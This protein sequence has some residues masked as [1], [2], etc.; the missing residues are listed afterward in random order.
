MRPA[1]A[2]SVGGIFDGLGVGW[3]RMSPPPD[4]GVR[5]VNDTLRNFCGGDRASAAE[6]ADLFMDR[7]RFRRLAAAAA[8]GREVRG[9]EM[10]LRTA[11]GR[12]RVCLL[13]LAPHRGPRGEVRWIDGALRDVTVERHTHRALGDSRGLFRAIFMHSPVGM[14]VL[15]PEGRLV[16]WNPAAREILGASER[17]LFNKPFRDLFRDREWQTVRRLIRRGR[18]SFVDVETQVVHAEG[19]VLDVSLSFARFQDAGGAD[20]GAI[21]ILHDIT[22][23]K[24][25]ER[26]IKESENKIRVILDN[27]AAAITLTDEKERIVSWNRYTEELL[28]R[29]REDLYLRPVSSLYPQEEWARIREANI[30]M[31]GSKHHFETRVIR[32]DGSCVDV[33]LS[34]NVLKDA[35][36]RIIGSVGIMQDITEQ[37]KFQQML[38]KAKTMAEEANS[39]KT[40]FLANM[41]HEVRTPMNTIIGMVDL[42]LDTNLTGEQRENLLAVKN[43]A[44]IL[45]NLINDIL[46]LSRVEAG[47]IQL[48]KIEMNVH[49]IVQSVC[50]GLI[51]LAR[52]KNLEL[53]W[54]VAPEV[55]ETVIGDPVRLRQVLVNLINNAVK[56]TFKGAITTRVEVEALDEQECT[57]RFSVIDEGVG[58][59]PEKLERIFD[60]FTQA[61]AST[62]RRF[63]GT[64]L[65]LAIS[66]RLVELMGGSIWVES[67]EF[68]GSTFSFTARFTRG[69]ETVSVP[70]EEEARGASSSDSTA[71]ER[72]L[73][74]LLAEDNIVNQKIAVRM[75]EKRGW[76]VT[77]V[78]NGR[79]VLEC[80]EHEDGFDLILMD[81]QMPVMD[82]LEA[83]RRIREAEKRSGGHIPIVALTAR[84][85][86]GDRRRCL[87]AGMD[88]YVSKPIDRQKLYEAVEALFR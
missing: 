3:F 48:E 19:R 57:L 18:R 60:A 77:A 1:H 26:R 55:P 43:A 13:S 34:V 68:R 85:M 17:E 6:A 31:L 46:D 40:L 15:D 63:G 72:P 59:P 61:D 47:K 16:A 42:T 5:A 32:G 87:D 38:M 35:D 10:E 83:T 14:I 51:V 8:S 9:E 41:S 80:L 4:G 66:R 62:T 30:R 76:R 23:Q 36:D 7:R 78:D 64:G 45:L 86:S 44:D 69:A 24:E 88:G 65:G 82:G 54:E 67:E 37:K 28:G 84:A 21:V 56:F 29:T 81:A 33:D 2:A 71:V 73:K 75:L 52:K 20:A 49:N 27:S 70:V 22:R 74:I 12:P 79:R 53:V 50:N 58:I 11:S 39:A 25:I